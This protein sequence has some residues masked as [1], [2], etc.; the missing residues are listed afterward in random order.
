MEN[1]TSRTIDVK[2]QNY[3][4]QL[5]F[6]FVN[7]TA[8]LDYQKSLQNLTTNRKKHKRRGGRGR[9]RRTEV[10]SN[11]KSIG[12]EF[13]TNSHTDLNF[14]PRHSGTVLGLCTLENT[15]WTRKFSF[16]RGN[17]KKWKRERHFRS[18]MNITKNFCVSNNYMKG[19]REINGS[20]VVFTWFRQY[21]FSVLINL[22]FTKLLL[23]K[24]Q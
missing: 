1:E 22:N 21:S 7:M 3:D 19:K 17:A 2:G 16:H 6:S 15:V 11:E 5:R 10:E 24:M 20:S 14:P 13:A 4:S 23:L 8:T 9:W 12:K 18:K